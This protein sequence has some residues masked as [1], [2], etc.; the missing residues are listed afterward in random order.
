MTAHQP[1]LGRDTACTTPR[2]DVFALVPATAMAILDVGCGNG[3]LGAS[4]R[5]AR[6]GR[7]V[8]GV[9]LDPVFAAQ[10]AGRLDHVL[11]AD[12]NQMDWP[13]LAEGR[14]FDRIVFADVLEHLTHPA[15]HL[16]EAQKRRLPGGC[17]VLSLPNSQ[18]IS[19]FCSIFVRGSFP[20]RAWRPIREL[21][22]YQFC[23]RAVPI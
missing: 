16:T 22:T 20:L 4:L 6:E 1:P 17:I 23:I 5:R 21:L 11:C 9:E 14:A 19:A 3:E 13:A 12:V 15:R 2:P 18:H 8:S 10:A 7:S